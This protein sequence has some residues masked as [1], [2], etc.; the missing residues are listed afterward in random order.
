MIRNVRIHYRYD[1]SA[2]ES[3]WVQTSM[4]NWWD[5][6]GD[7]GSFSVSVRSSHDII[8]HFMPKQSGQ[9]HEEL[10]ALG[11]AVFREPFHESFLMDPVESLA[12]D[13]GNA[14]ENASSANSIS[15]KKA[16]RLRRPDNVSDYAFNYVLGLIK[17][18]T[19]RLISDEKVLPIVN[20]SS[21]GDNGNGLIKADRGT[22]AYFYGWLR[23]GV[24]KG[25]RRYNEP[26]IAKCL[27]QEIDSLCSNLNKQANEAGVRGL[28]WNPRDK[29][30]DIYVDLLLDMD[31]ATVKAKIPKHLEDVFYV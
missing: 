15:W 1:D 21:W 17:D 6:S 4:L 20:E 30:E 5:E 19:S 23:Y 2:G 12:S 18:A 16:P 3:G 7:Y 31:K 9:L 10:I 22:R 11:V 27:A 28:D 8:D 13:I 29:Q 14:W 25:F 26:W 24:I